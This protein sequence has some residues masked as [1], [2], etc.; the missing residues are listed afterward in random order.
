MR[1]A[2]A[3]LGMLYLAGDAVAADCSPE[4]F[5]QGEDKYDAGETVNLS[6]A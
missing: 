3:F 2:I 6:M 1:V 5:K 4:F